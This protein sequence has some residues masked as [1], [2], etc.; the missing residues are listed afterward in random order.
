M[1]AFFGRGLTTYDVPLRIRAATAVGGVPP[2]DVWLATADLPATRAVAAPPAFQAPAR[3]TLALPPTPVTLVR[4]PPETVD[5]PAAIHVLTW[6]PPKAAVRLPAVPPFIAPLRR[7][8][9]LVPPRIREDLD[10]AR[11]QLVRKRL[12]PAARLSADEAARW[13]RR[14]ADSK[15]MAKTRLELVGVFPDV[16]VVEGAPVRYDAGAGAIA[17]ALPATPIPL[18]TVVVARRTDTGVAVIGRFYR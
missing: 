11:A 17:Y 15:K 8:D 6:L 5:P 1:C 10:A 14:L 4:R 18:S 12:V 9:A 3:L 7:A 2:I 16:P 13:L